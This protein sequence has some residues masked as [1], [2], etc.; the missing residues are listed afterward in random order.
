MKYFLTTLLVVLMISCNST[1][2]LKKEFPCATFSSFSNL[3]QTEDV[4]NL[5][6]MS[7]PK[8]WKVNL[9]F[10]NVQTAIYTADTTVNLTKT[11]IMDASYIHSAIN[12][13]AVFQQKMT[14]DNTKMELTETKA[15]KITLFDKPSYISYATGKKGTYSYHVLNTFT[16][17]NS[18]NFLHIKTE[19]YGD[20]KV[21]ERLCN[22]I[23]L[24]D[25]I[26]LK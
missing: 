22:A 25:K 11:I 5:F 20:T 21:E 1:S 3:Q 4:R 18:D 6:S 10:D 16:K 19:I 24:I 15:K 23:N 26:Q 17:V 8:N 2:E 9:F 13:D 12:F 7:L 14:A